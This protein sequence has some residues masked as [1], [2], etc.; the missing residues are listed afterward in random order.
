MS[1]TN[2]IGPVVAARHRAALDSYVGKTE[3]L[4]RR[5]ENSVLIVKTQGERQLWVSPDYGSY[6]D[7]WAEAFPDQP[8]PKGFD[9]DHVHNS[10]RAA[11]E[12]WGY[13]RL[14]CIPASANRRAAGNHEGKNTQLF[15]V[16]KTLLIRT[17]DHSQWSKLNT[18]GKLA[19]YEP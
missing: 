14:A 9:I 6:R 8:I 15:V 7:A 3:A 12:G 19:D 4:G 2:L 18:S 10:D 13:V 11:K 17:I 5:R 16:N 1:H